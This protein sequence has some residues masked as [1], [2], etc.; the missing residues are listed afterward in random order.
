MERGTKAV[1][2]NE[3]KRDT[4]QMFIVEGMRNHSFIILSS[5]LDSRLNFMS[6]ADYKV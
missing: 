1:H 6:Q 4:I 5:L 3:G 2:M